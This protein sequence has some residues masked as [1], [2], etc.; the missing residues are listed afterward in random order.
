MYGCGGN[1]PNILDMDSDD[2][3]RAMSG[4]TPRDP[5]LPR[6]ST[7]KPQAPTAAQQVK[8]GAARVAQGLISCGKF[9]A[10]TAAAC[11]QAAQ[12]GVDQAR[13]DLKN[14]RETKILAQIRAADQRLAV[15]SQKL[16]Q[17]QAEVAQA[18]KAAAAASK[19]IPKPPPRA[20]HP[21]VERALP[22]V[23]VAGNIAVG[24]EVFRAL[25]GE[26]NRSINAIGGSRLYTEELDK[27][28][29]KLAKKN[30]REEL[31]VSMTKCNRSRNSL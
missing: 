19:A 8:A 24:A 20:L 29:E 31:A 23:R 11:L 22:V 26:L 14:A 2:L 28:S 13:I 1:G 4:E 3:R 21:V 27:I 25:D 9:A 7:P 6:S 16:A 10:T 30:P 15:A 17:V 5:S 18:E 12:N